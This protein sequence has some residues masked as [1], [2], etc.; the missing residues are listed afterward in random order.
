VQNGSL[1]SCNNCCKVL[2]QLED[3]LQQLGKR[4]A[5]TGVWFCNNHKLTH[6]SKINE[7]Y[8]ISLIFNHNSYEILKKCNGK[9]L[10]SKSC[11]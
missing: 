11:I 1:A 10:G 4:V 9:H 3:V 6:S 2:Q 5:T 7:K 8:V